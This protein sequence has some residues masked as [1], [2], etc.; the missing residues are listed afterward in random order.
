MIDTSKY[1][2]IGI[3]AGTFRLSRQIF[4]KS[5]VLLAYALALTI[6]GLLWGYWGYICQTGSSI[7]C[8]SLTGS[9]YTSIGLFIGVLVFAYLYLT[10]VVD[11][12]EAAFC[13]MP[14]KINQVWNVSKVKSKAALVVLAY[15]AVFIVPVAIF[16]KILMLPA[17]SDWRVEMIN[18]LLIFSLFMAQL[19]MLRTIASLSIY[20]QHK[21]FPSLMQLFR[22]TT[23]SGYV[24]I[25]LFLILFAFS[26]LFYMVITAK[27]N[28]FWQN[29]NSLL[30]MLVKMFIDN[31]LK[32]FFVAFLI[33]FCRAQHELLLPED[34]LAEDAD[35]AE[36]EPEE[37]EEEIAK[38][39]IVTKAK[40]SKTTKQTSA[41]KTTRT[42]KAKQS[43]AK[44]TKKK[45]RATKKNTNK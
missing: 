26:L 40:K 34:L 2:M 27:L 22:Q 43:T 8:Y 32:L 19:F 14:F 5:Q 28:G 45:T 10:Y 25:I 36:Q 11:F 31:V 17:N 30:I 20:L 23:G 16:A 44:E 41:K 38:A 15:I 21:K 33:T 6:C 35:T 24:S 4:A 18:F 39:P 42:S 12:Y 37:T 1:S 13:K 7:L 29:S 3:M 9:P